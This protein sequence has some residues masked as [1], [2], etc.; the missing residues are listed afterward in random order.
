M[1]S[2][3]G[4]EKTFDTCIK[5]R[6]DSKSISYIYMNLCLLRVLD[7]DLYL[8][9]YIYVSMSVSMSMYLCICLHLDPFFYPHLHFLVLTLSCIWIQVRYP[10][11][12]F[13]LLE[14]SDA[15]SKQPPLARDG[16]L[17]RAVVLA[18]GGVGNLLYSRL[19]IAD[20]C[21]HTYM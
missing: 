10:C 18:A 9:I 8:Y 11:C 5:P 7:L 21:T 3:R 14:A 6:S 1:A 19:C 4:Q 17:L 16:R 2:E 15:S 13:K 12:S 20:A